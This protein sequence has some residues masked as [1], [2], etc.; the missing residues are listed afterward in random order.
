M[1]LLV[2]LMHPC[3]IKVLIKTDQKLLNYNVYKLVITLQLKQYSS[4][5]QKPFFHTS[6]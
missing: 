6:S 3:G 5:F 2:N 1:S 4:T